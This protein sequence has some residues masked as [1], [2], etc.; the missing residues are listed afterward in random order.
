MYDVPTGV[1]LNLVQLGIVSFWTLAVD[2]AQGFAGA[3][4]HQQKD[5]VFRPQQKGGLFCDDAYNFR[6][7]ALGVQ[8]SG[9]I[10]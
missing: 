9:Q 7:I 4:I 5:G 6:H 10:D 1:E 2:R 8:N 3:R